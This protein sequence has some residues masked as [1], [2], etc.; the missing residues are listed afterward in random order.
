[1]KKIKKIAASIMAVAAMATSVTGISASAST[2]NTDTGTYCFWDWGINAS[3]QVYAYTTNIT[4]GSKRVASGVTVYQ[5][6]TGDYITYVGD[7]KDG[8]NGT[9]STA[10]VSRN[11]YPSNG[12]NF[13][14]SGC[15]Y[16]STNPYSGVL[17]S[18]G[19]KKIA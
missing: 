9:M 14:C 2:L 12:Y 10:K 15:I 19:P 6:G 7:Y 8:G 13:V 18:W 3:N 17:E 11:T 1:M 5:D 4:Y 16:N